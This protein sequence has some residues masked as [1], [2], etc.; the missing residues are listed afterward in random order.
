MLEGVHFFWPDQ[1]MN[2]TFQS[3]GAVV[4]IE[5]CHLQRKYFASL[6][7]SGSRV[8]ETR[9]FEKDPEMLEGVLF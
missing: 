1:L 9:W 6:S 3:V 4:S 2:Q 8:S 7:N 5:D